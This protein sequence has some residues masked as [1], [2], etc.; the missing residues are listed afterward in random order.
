MV[1]G[2]PPDAKAG[3][4]QGFTLL[5]ILIGVCVLAI[6]TACLM[7]YVSSLR[8]SLTQ[9]SRL[10]DATR[11][12]STALEVLKGELK[13]SV[14][15]KTLYEDAGRQPVRKEVE[16]DINNRK[17]SVTLTLTRAPAPLYALKARARAAWNGHHDVEVGVLLPGPSD[18]L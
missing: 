18:F 2:N 16:R 9:G 6:T 5:E 1:T 15:F 4:R 7:A 17:Y 3:S 11:A 13:D 14:A 8:K 12:A 10:G